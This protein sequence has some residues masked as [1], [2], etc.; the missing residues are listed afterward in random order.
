MTFKQTI[1]SIERKIPDVFSS[2]EII[3]TKIQKYI[4]RSI[5]LVEG[6]KPD[7]ILQKYTPLPL[8]S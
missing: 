1:W 6:E 8:E 3:N 2:G 4:A 7:D 5:F